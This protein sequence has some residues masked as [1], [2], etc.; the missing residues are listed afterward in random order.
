MVRKESET[1]ADV[2]SDFFVS[3]CS[4]LWQ[5]AHSG[6]LPSLDYQNLVATLAENIGSAPLGPA[7]ALAVLMAL[8]ALQDTCCR[9]LRQQLQLRKEE[10]PYAVLTAIRFAATEIC[11]QLNRADATFGQG[12]KAVPVIMEVVEA[13]CSCLLPISALEWEPWMVRLAACS[14]ALATFAAAELFLSMVCVTRR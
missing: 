3:L 8:T 13:W 9:A 1:P 14:K 12:A 6:V 7:V 2:D 5:V 10:E 4:L 11:W